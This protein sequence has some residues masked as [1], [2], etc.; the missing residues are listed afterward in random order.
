M[1]TFNRKVRDDYL[2]MIQQFPLTPIRSEPQYRAALKMID[3]LSARPASSLT[4]GE[5]DYLD[6]LADLVEKY[7]DANVSLDDVSPLDA[8]RELLDQHG[9][10]A[11]DLGRL[12]GNRQLGA[13]I[14]RGDRGLSKAHI[15]ILSKRFA[16]SA[17]LFLD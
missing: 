15:S 11:S 17:S 12:L 14:L 16:V 6:V 3:K 7:E 13:A 5:S 9:M 10:S 2:A 8:L 4:P 1:T